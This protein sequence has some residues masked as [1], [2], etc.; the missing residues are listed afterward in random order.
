VRHPLSA[1]P[2][3]NEVQDSRPQPIPKLIAETGK[4]TAVLGLLAGGELRGA[5]EGHG[6]G[7]IFGAGTDS[8]LLRTTLNHGMNH[9]PAADH[10]RA[11]AL[12]APDLMGREAKEIAEDLAQAEGQIAECLNCVGVKQDT[13]SPA[14]PPDLGD[15]LNHSCLVVH[16]HNRDDSRAPGQDLVEMVEVDYSVAIDCNA[17]FAATEMGNGVRSRQHRLVLDGRHGGPHRP[18]A[19]TCRKR[20][21]QDRQVVCFGSAG[22]EE[23]LP[24]LGANGLGDL[25]AGSIQA[26]ARGPSGL[27]CTRGITKGLFVEVREHSVP[28]LGAHR[29]RR[30]V[31]EIDERLH[32]GN[33]SGRSTGHMLWPSSFTTS[34]TTIVS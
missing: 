20:G 32:G 18:A 27:V 13:R 6:A 8:G 26:R 10:E 5:T 15:W 23:Y 3:Y 25:P 21:A 34:S 16:P 14:P 28:R 12:R 9:V 11:D 29:C 7:D 4:M 24:G 22:R 1:L 17:L 19:V 2:D 30:G 33:L 31:I